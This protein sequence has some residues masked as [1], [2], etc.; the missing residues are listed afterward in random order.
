MEIVLELIGE[1]F[2][3]PIVSFVVQV[4]QFVFWMCCWVVVSVCRSVVAVAR[5][6]KDMQ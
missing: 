1:F 2:I 4:F 6:R 3:K 5:R